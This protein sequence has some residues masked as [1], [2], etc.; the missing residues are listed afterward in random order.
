MRYAQVFVYA[1]L[2]LVA[3][4]AAYLSWTHE[5]PGGKGDVLVID[6]DPDQLQQV[7]YEEP[8][9]RVQVARQEGGEDGICWGDTF[10]RKDAPKKPEPPSP[11]PLAGDDDSAEPADGEVEPEPEKIEESKSFRGNQTCDKILARFAPMRAIREFE[12]LTDEKLTE[13]ELTE[14]SATL[15]VT[16]ARG[17]R[18]FEVGG[19]SYG[20]ND[21][22]LRDQASGVVYLVESRLVADIKGGST[23]LMERSLH[24]FKKEDVERAVVVVEG[25]QGAFVQ[26]NR[27]DSKTAVWAAADDTSRAHDGADAWLDKVLRLRALE[28]Y[29]D[30]LAALEPQA[31]VEFASLDG[32]LGWMEFG[33]AVDGEGEPIHVA[34][35][36]TSIA[37]VK[38][39]DTMGG[40]VL[41]GLSAVFPPS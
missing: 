22:Y 7:V 24:A 14:P 13:M 38:V 5:P 32:P 39:S 29:T 27:D 30:P 25:Q 4:I 17:E 6:A 2:L 34:R 23:R 10:K 26:L 37:W 19:R 15:A 16:T 28:Y 9:H 1:G 21:Y 31:R 11:M 36:S 40:D 20:T 33:T 41:E 12:Q 18:T 8:D 3:L 35:S